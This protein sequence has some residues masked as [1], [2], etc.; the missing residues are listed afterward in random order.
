VQSR[1]C[2]CVNVIEQMT[3][4]YKWNGSLQ[5]DDEALLIIKTKTE[6]LN[7]LRE[8]VIQ[9]HPYDVPEFISVPI[10][11]ASEPYVKWLN[12]QVGAQPPPV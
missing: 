9:K 8:A 7:Q 3:S 11:F 4:I 1:L 12:E 10:E 2:A 5:E 6:Y